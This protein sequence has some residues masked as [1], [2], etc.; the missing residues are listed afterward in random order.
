MLPN[1]TLLANNHLLYGTKW[2]FILIMILKK[3]IIL[4]WQVTIDQA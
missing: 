2:S 4:K 1:A 3:R